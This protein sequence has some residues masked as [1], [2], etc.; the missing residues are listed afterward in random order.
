MLRE[1]RMSEYV[2]K[3]WPNQWPFGKKKID[4]CFGVIRKLVAVL[5]LFCEDPALGD[6]VV[7]II[8][9]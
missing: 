7:V 8:V 9:R 3:T 4:Q 2:V 6:L 5:W 1:E